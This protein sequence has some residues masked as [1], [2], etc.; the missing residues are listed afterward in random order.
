[1]KDENG[2]KPFIPADGQYTGRNRTAG[3]PYD[4]SVSGTG[5]LGIFTS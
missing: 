5:N 3:N 1:M 2:F 4:R